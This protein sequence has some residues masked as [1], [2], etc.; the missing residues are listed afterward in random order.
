MSKKAACSVFVCNSKKSSEEELKQQ[1][2]SE[3][4]EKLFEILFCNSEFVFTSEIVFY[5]FFYNNL[6]GKKISFLIRKSTEH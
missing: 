3:L 2:P 1:E 4:K 6:R 5:I